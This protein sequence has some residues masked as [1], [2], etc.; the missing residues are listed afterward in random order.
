MI[1]NSETNDIRDLGYVH[2]SS[3]VNIVR[4]NRK[5]APDLLAVA[6]TNVDFFLAI[7][8]M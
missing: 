8:K 2:R 1:W 4:W 6:C 7:L 3:S 5:W